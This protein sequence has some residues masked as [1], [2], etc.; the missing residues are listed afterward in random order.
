MGVNITA[1]T[2][3]PIYKMCVCTQW[4]MVVGVNITAITIVPIYKMCVCTQWQVVVGVNI[5]AITI[6]PIYKTCVCVCTVAGG[7]GCAGDPVQTAA[8][9]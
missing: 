9:P 5:T 7:G 2:I 6:V 1:I 8:G 4:Q 3:V